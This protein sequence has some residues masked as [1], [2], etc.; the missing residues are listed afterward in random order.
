MR[1][2]AIVPSRGCYGSGSRV[3]ALALRADRA[4]AIRL[5]K[6]ATL[7]YRASMRSVGGSSGGY[8]VVVAPE[9]AQNRLDCVWRYG[10]ELDGLPSI[11]G[12]E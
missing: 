9:G 2:Y 12:D 3:T 7:E 11:D 5:A 10:H 1:K 8:R 4:V 6:T